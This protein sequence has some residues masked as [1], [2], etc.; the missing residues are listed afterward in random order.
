MALFRRSTPEPAPSLAGQPD[1]EDK[2]DRLRRHASEAVTTINRASGELPTYSC[3]QALHL[4]DL[5]TEV[6]DLSDTRALDI[7]AA[8][9]VRRTLSEYLP[10]TIAAFRKIPATARHEARPSGR[11]PVTALE[12]SLS[13]MQQAARETL[14]AAQNHDV[15]A[16]M[17]QG[18]FLTTKFSR[19]DLDL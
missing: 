4:V 15:D 5:L 9:T 18:A 1:A 13:A 8:I 14:L 2:P 3:V 7:H 11:T 17:T 19:S 12:E 10:D 16:L 6:I